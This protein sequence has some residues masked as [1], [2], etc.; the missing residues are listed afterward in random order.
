MGSKGR[1]NISPVQGVR[2]NRYSG[3]KMTNWTDF[4]PINSAIDKIYKRFYDSIYD[5]ERT[6]IFFHQEAVHKDFI[7]PISIDDIKKEIDKLPN[8]FTHGLKA[9]FLLAGSNKQMRVFESK[10]F[11]Y[12]TYWRDIIFIHPFPKKNMNLYYRNSLKP[13]VKNDYL[14]V[15]AILER[16]DK[17]GLWVKWD[18]ENLKIFYL[19]DVLIHEIGHHF[20]N[21]DKMTEGFAEWFATEYGFKFKYYQDSI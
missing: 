20:D 19:R 5:K 1:P 2:S 11:A 15:G 16:D 3:S 9:I 14:R 17:I 7:M 6:G 18:P 10:L 12:G 8:N 4:D 21:R 13:N